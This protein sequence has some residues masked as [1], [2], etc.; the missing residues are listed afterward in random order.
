VKAVGETS[1]TRRSVMHIEKKSLVNN[2]VAAATII[3]INSQFRV[4]LSKPAPFRVLTCAAS[5]K[6]LKNVTID[7]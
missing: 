2:K 1:S 6:H 7:F 5:G 4:D 3:A